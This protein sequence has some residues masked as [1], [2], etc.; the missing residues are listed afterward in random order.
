MKTIL[1]NYLNMEFFDPF[2]FNFKASV[3]IERLYIIQ[4]NNMIVNFEMF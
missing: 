2:I 1:R 3:F 4:H